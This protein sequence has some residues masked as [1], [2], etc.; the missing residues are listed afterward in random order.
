MPYLLIQTNVE[1]DAEQQMTLV[2]Q[3]S[4]TVAAILGKSEDYVMVTLQPNTMMSFAGGFESAAYLELKSLDLPEQQTAQFS[5]TLCQ[6]IEQ[7][8]NISPTRIYIE[9]SNG[10]RSLWGWNGKTF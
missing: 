10:Q 3:A 9:F 4:K 5:A 1:L 6:L 8:L 7:M 2:S